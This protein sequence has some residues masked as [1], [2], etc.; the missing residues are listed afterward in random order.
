MFTVVQHHNSW[1]ISVGNQLQ[2]FSSST[3]CGCSCL[4]LLFVMLPFFF[5]TGRKCGLQV[6]Q[7]SSRILSIKPRCWRSC[8]M[9][10]RVCRTEV[11]S[12]QSWNVA[13]S[14]SD[15]V[16]GYISRCGGRLLSENGFPGSFWVRVIIL[17]I[18]FLNC[19]SCSAA[20]VLNAHTHPTVHIFIVPF[21]PL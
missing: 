19:F 1:G 2:D 16:S 6:G 9:R 17:I 20:W 18:I 13:S 7:E 14:L 3:V 12:A 8:R 4:V 15:T 21:N 11:F 10:S 5:T